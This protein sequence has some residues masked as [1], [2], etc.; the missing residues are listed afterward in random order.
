MREEF[1]KVHQ[2]IVRNGI[3]SIINLKPEN[4]DST[5]LLPGVNPILRFPLS[6]VTSFNFTIDCI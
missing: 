6:P 2:Q 4:T 5:H 1:G 3:N